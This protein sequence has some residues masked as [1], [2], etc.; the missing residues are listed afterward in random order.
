VPYAEDTPQS[1]TDVTVEMDPFGNQYLHLI[2]PADRINFLNG[3]SSGESFFSQNGDAFFNP[4]EP[5]MIEVGCKV[6]EVNRI[7]YRANPQKIDFDMT[8]A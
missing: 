2:L 3:M 5:V 1:H 7:A 8:F 6:F 4:V